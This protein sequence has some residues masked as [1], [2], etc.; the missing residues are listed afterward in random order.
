M[1]R[2]RAIIIHDNQ[3]TLSMMMY[4]FAI[5]GGYEVLTYQK[6]DICPLW[7]DH[8]NCSKSHPCA[9]ILIAD[10]RSA[11]M[12]GVALFRQQSR[13]GCSIPMNHK[14]L[15]SG[16]AEDGRAKEISTMGCAFFDQPVDFVKMSSWLQVRELN[17]DLS[18]PLVIRRREYRQAIREKVAC[19]IAS[20]EKH[21]I[22]TAVN[23]SPSGLCLQSTVPL[24][25]EQAV[26][27]SPANS[28]S[29]RP[30]LVRWTTKVEAGAYLT[31]LQF[32]HA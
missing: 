26:H 32:M 21:F 29:A 8:V 16:N 1:R 4:Y 3:T 20:T 14:A 13:K 9:D 24:R 31:G 2:R 23:S 19:L 30:A 15:I 18:Q 28:T 27:V 22:G 11:T 6:P 25:Q 5:R 17:M 12:E 7:D 10:F